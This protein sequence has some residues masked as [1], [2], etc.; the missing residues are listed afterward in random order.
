MSDVRQ[1]RDAARCLG[2]GVEPVGCGPHR[3]WLVGQVALGHVFDC[4]AKDAFARAG[5]GLCQHRHR[6]YAGDGARRL[7][8]QSP[9]QGSIG[10]AALPRAQ[11]RVSLEEL[12][13]GKQ[14]PIRQWVP[15]QDARQVA[16]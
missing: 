4:R 1:R 10:R 11:L 15:A 16:L 14:R 8:S 6:R 7:D 9:D 3:T 2:I 12:A 5:K 13:L